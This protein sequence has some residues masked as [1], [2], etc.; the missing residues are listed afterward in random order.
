MRPVADQFETSKQP[1]ATNIGNV[2]ML[3]KTAVQ[4]ACQGVAE[5][6]DLPEHGRLCNL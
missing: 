5:L 6:L 3:C 4:P 2:G 1:T